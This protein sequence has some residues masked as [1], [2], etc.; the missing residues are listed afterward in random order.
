MAG[1][2]INAC[3]NYKVPGLVADPTWAL[4]SSFKNIRKASESRTDICPILILIFFNTSRNS[5]LLPKS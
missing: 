4:P 2:S 3:K 5:K 1:P